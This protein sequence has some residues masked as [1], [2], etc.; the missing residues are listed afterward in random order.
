MLS[1]FYLESGITFNMFKCVAWRGEFTCKVL[2]Y[3]IFKNVN[4]Y[5]EEA[6]GFENLGLSNF[7]TTLLCYFIIFSFLFFAFCLVHSIYFLKKFYSKINLLI[8][9]LH[10]ADAY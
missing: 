3:K 1:Y 8:T 7:R 10:I 4:D 6:T 9:L 2:G 5:I